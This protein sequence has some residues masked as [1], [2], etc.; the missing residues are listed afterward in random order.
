M[1]SGLAARSKQTALLASGIEDRSGVSPA[2]ETRE[3]RA[4][5]EL[6]DG[7]A[8]VVADELLPGGPFIHRG[9]EYST[10]TGIIQSD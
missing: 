5:T 10:L 3:G 4:A 1:R 2:G 8:R 7:K 9:F 6:C